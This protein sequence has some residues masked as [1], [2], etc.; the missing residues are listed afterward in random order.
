M[1]NKH[2]DRFESKNE[3]RGSASRPSEPTSSTANNPSVYKQPP[4]EEATN[5]GNTE[6][7]DNDSKE[8]RKHTP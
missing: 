3:P 2:D 5:A 4:V 7:I 1:D 8:D 6:K